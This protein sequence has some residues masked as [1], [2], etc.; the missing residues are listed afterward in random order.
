ML[1]AIPIYSSTLTAQEFRFS[2]VSTQDT[3]EFI[4]RKKLILYLI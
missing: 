1:F 3:F 4:I 2:P